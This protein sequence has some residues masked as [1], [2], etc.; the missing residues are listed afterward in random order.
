MTSKS[1][2][3]TIIASVFGLMLSLTLV[4]GVGVQTASAALTAAQVDA[5][6]SLLNSFGADASTVSGWHAVGAD[7]GY[8]VH[9]YPQPH[10]R[11]HGR[12]C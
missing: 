8:R 3:H 6:I 5:I 9:L 11:R 12:R 2:K 4:A 1:K 7:Y 10:R